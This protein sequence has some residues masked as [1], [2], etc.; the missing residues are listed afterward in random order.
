MSSNS[1]TKG[2]GIYGWV[3]IIVMFLACFVGIGVF[4]SV[5]VTGDYLQNAFGWNTTTVQSTVS[6]G[7]FLSVFGQAAFG[8]LLMKRSSKKLALI[9]GIIFVLSVAGISL[10]TQNTM[11]LYL[12]AFIVMKII[13][14]IWMYMVNGQMLANWFPKKRSTIMGITTFGI[15]LGAGV[16]SAIVAMNLGGGLKTAFIPFIILAVIAILLQQI[17]MKDHPEQA[18]RFPDNE[19]TDPEVA[20]AHLEAELKAMKNS[21]WTVKRVLSIPHTWFFILSVGF[22]LL[23]GAGVM[24]QIVP[25]M[26][27]IDPEFGME[28]GT[29]VLTGVSVFSCIGSFICGLLDSRFGTKRA[30][31]ISTISMIVA[32]ALAAIGNL[33]TTFIALAILSIY[34]GGGSNFAMSGCV[35]YF[36][37]AGFAGAFRVIQPIT[38]LIASFG[39]VLI[40]ALAEIGS[41]KLSFGFIAVLGLISMILTLLLKEDVF[42][43]K[44]EQFLAEASE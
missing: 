23:A 34:V 40:A 4:N 35:A 6:L 28:Y 27:Q 12:V 3:L 29:L 8:Q 25:M 37:R 30:I 26:I 9:C 7:A 43:K 39:A 32:G 18:G 10:S 42:K 2:Y 13:S 21:P 1:T 5:N 24:T 36:G 41:Y 44:E 16:G 20:K 17:V 38:A 31:L 19:K 33:I 11:W 22:L 15:P 14:D